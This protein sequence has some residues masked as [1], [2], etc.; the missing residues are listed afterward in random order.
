MTRLD[1]PQSGP[2]IEEKDEKEKLKEEIR[3]E[4]VAGMK[5]KRHKKF[6]TCCL[7]ELLFVLLILV[8]IAT[9]VAKTGLVEIP[10]FSKIFSKVSSPQRVVTITPEEIKNF[11]TDITKKLEQ[12]VKSAIVPG[13]TDQEVEISLEFTEKELTV[14]LQT[15]GS[16]GN[17]PLLNPQISITPEGL[18][19]FGEISE[20]KKMYLTINIK[21]EIRDNNLEIKI[22]KIK[23][24]TLSL[25]AIFGNFLV[26]RILKTQLDEVRDEISKIGKLENINLEDG[27]ITLRGL[28]DILVFTE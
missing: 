21:P 20:P 1:A 10:V 25:P 4:V 23:I 11:D 19:I 18:E 14:L 12:E 27:K 6:L 16:N 26:E 28:V 17:L 3:E 2:W 7:L 13:R 22:K 5:K 24:G 8:L 15:L 9:A